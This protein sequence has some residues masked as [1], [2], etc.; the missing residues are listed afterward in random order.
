MPKKVKLFQR[1]V[2]RVHELLVEFDGKEL[3]HVDVE[4]YD[5]LHTRDLKTN[6]GGT[7]FY[8]SKCIK[9]GEVFCIN[10]RIL[11]V[12]DENKNEYTDDSVKIIFDFCAAT[13]FEDGGFFKLSD[14]RVPVEDVFQVSFADL[15]KQL[16]FDE[17]MA[18]LEVMEAEQETVAVVPALTTTTGCKSTHRPQVH[19]KM[20]GA[21]TGHSKTAGKK[22]TGKGDSAKA[23]TGHSKMVDA[24]HLKIFDP[25]PDPRRLLPAC[26]RRSCTASRDG[27]RSGRQPPPTMLRF[28]LPWRPHLTVKKDFD[29]VTAICNHKVTHNYD[30]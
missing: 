4:G 28:V 7:V 26:H 17:I 15:S 14:F 12:R 8:I 10:K 11:A 6:K 2:V 3:H 16:S 30:E 18:S 23:P 29:A 9:E 13:A 22:T 20:I 5:L 21:P 25:P 19:S 24:P 1:Q 27:Y